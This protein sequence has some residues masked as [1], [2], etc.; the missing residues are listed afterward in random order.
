MKPSQDSRFKCVTV[1]TFFDFRSR[2]Q[3]ICERTPDYGSHFVDNL[4]FSFSFW[5]LAYKT[6]DF[7]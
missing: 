1:D 4:D 6:V 5:T 7:H 3:E 2:L